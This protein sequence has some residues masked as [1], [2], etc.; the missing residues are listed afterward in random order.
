MNVESVVEQSMKVVYLVSPSYAPIEVMQP[1]IIVWSCLRQRLDTWSRLWQRFQFNLMLQ[2]V[3][4]PEVVL[5]GAHT[6]SRIVQDAWD[7]TMTD[8]LY[9]G[10]EH[11]RTSCHGWSVHICACGA[12]WCIMTHGITPCIVMHHHAS[13]HESIH[14]GTCGA[15]WCMMIHG[16]APCIVMHHGTPSC[17]S[18]TC[19]GCCYD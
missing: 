4:E 19:E 18:V 5:E 13:C 15:W 11:H 9:F 7:T 17:K 8:S 16:M 6:R 12:L 14:L 2:L 3:A 10:S 1:C